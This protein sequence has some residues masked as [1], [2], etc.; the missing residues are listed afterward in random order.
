MKYERTAATRLRAFAIATAAVLAAC[1]VSGTERRHAVEPVELTAENLAHQGLYVT[2]C[3]S[4]HE[5]MPDPSE[6]Y[7]FTGVSAEDHLAI[8]QYEMAMMND[9]PEFSEQG[10]A[11]FEEACVG[12]HEL[13]DPAQPGC[14]SG[15]ALEEVVP[16]HVY[17]ENARMG[18]EVFETDCRSCH[19]EL[20]PD[21]HDLEYWSTHLCNE[22]GHL[23]AE[24][25][26]RVLVFLTFRGRQAEER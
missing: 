15:A 11:L 23:S 5:R 18:R 17:M 19:A 3:D 22:D 16:I 26:Q 24:D 21:S 20:E 2:R 12:C 13:P 8:W 4:C 14:F 1:E 6:P 25:E 10:K 9:D 7:C